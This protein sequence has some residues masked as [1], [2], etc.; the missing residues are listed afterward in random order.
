MKLKKLTLFVL[1]LSL[2]ECAYAQ[3]APFFKDIQNFKKK[4]SLHFPPKNAVLFVGSS[5]FTNWKD[6]QFYFD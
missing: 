2:F 3:E 6:V 1:F 4:D 5:T